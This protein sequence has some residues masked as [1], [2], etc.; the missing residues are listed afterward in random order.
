MPNHL[1]VSGLTDAVQSY[2]NLMYDSDVTRFDRVFRSTA[3]RDTTG[4]VS[5][6]NTILHDTFAAVNC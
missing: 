5:Y 4:W 1:D 2:F 3:Q 6:F